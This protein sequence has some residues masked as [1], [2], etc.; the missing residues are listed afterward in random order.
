M[1]DKA[2]QSRIISNNI[3]KLR[4]QN[5]WNQSTLANKAG[6]TPAALSQIEKGDKRLPSFV[7]LRKLASALNVQPFE[8]TGEAPPQTEIDQKS[9]E[10]YRRWDLLEN[11]SENDQKMLREMAE[12]L[13]GMTDK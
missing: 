10:F 2:E 12:R 1:S 3:K 6:I 11:L 5:G 13:K 8:L 9:R 4:D 7:V